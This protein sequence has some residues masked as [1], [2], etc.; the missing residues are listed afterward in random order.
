[1]PRVLLERLLRSDI[2]GAKGTMTQCRYLRLALFLAATATFADAAIGT[3]TP[4]AC[5]ISFCASMLPPTWPFTMD[6]SKSAQVTRD[7]TDRAPDAVPDTVA[8]PLAG[9]SARDFVRQLYTI[10]YG[11]CTGVA[12]ELMLTVAAQLTSQDRVTLVAYLTLPNPR[13][14]IPKDTAC[15]D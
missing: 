5:A 7:A 3:A 4:S 6:S 8:L 11:R 15:H 10:Q 12:V 13:F 14:S 9:H 1:M 2:R